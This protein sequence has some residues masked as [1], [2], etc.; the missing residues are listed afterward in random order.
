MKSKEKLEDRLIKYLM[1]NRK[2]PMK[3]VVYF[4]LLTF[5]NLKNC[6]TIDKGNN[7]QS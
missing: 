1:D 6:C 4:A 5:K 2:D 3:K 7:G